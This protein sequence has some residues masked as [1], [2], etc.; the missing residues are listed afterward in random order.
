MPQ[1][2]AE[3]LALAVAFIEADE[4]FPNRA[5]DSSGVIGDAMHAAC[6]L[7]LR[8]ASRCESPAGDWPDRIAALVA[9]DAPY[10][11]RVA[12]LR[13]SAAERCGDAGPGGFM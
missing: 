6:V 7:W 1:D 13:G 2:P 5:D 11:G 8:A 4:V 10:P 3:A 12:A 9:A